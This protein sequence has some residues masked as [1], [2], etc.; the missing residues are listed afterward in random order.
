M[1]AVIYTRVSTE[2]Q[3]QSGA[4]LSAQEK[5]CRLYASQNEI[6]VL[7]HFEELGKSAKSANRPVFQKMLDFCAKNPGEIDCLIVWKLDRFARN[8]MDHLIISA[9]LKA[10]GIRLISVTEYI[11]DSPMGKAVETMMA[12]LA[13]MENQTKADRTVLGMTERLSQGGWPHHAPIGYVNQKDSQ[14]CPTLFPSEHAHIVTMMFERYATGQ[15]SVSELTSW[16]NAEGLRTRT[17]API[18]QQTVSKILRNPIYAGTIRSPLLDTDVDGIHLPLVDKTVF[19][20]VQQ[21]LNGWQERLPSIAEGW[22]LRGKFV[23]C[24]HCK[25]PL[26]GGAPKSRSGKYY[27]RYQCRKCRKKDVGVATSVV[28]NS[29]HEEFAASL[30]AIELKD[31]ELK[32]FKDSVLKAWQKSTKQSRLDRNRYD[33]LLDE[34]KRK[35][36]RLLDLYIDGKLSEQDKSAKLSECDAEILRLSSLRE[37]VNSVGTMSDELISYAA[38]FASNLAKMWVDGDLHAKGVLQSLVFP[39]GVVYDFGKGFRTAKLGTIFRY[40]QPIKEDETNRNNSLV[41]WEGIEPPTLSL[42]RRRSIH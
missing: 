3:A 41:P 27:A 1:R 6:E 29:F 24:G 37:S 32:D 21:V 30:S 7:H 36:S 28:R 9:Q 26:T 34:S 5:S 15:V 13:E 11:E 20:R 19:L 12:A 10:I 2:E 40:R 8:T 38:Y 23:V 25:L 17:D 42:G 18:L 39:E 16:A 22:P 4:S 31:Q 35:K 33:K 14:G